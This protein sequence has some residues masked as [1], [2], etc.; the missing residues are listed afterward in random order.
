MLLFENK[1]RKNAFADKPYMPHFKTK[2]MPKGLDPTTYIL[3]F[4]KKSDFV[5]YDLCT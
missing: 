3:I 1:M 2:D 5:R 4:R